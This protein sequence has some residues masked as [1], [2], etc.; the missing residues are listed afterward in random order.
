MFDRPSAGE[1]AVVIQLDFGRRDLKE[2]LEEVRLLIESAG[3]QVVAEVT[4][5]RQAPD[6]SDR[7][8]VVL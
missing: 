5:R 1:R 6:K 2:D 4:G 3:G 8:H 7:S